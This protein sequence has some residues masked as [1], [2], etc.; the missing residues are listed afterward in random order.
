ML[1]K[2]KFN[3]EAVTNDSDIFNLNEESDY[4]A[5]QETHDQLAD[6]YE[7]QLIA[8]NA[9]YLLKLRSN[10]A[11]T[12]NAIAYIIS[13]TNVAVNLAITAVKEGILAKLSSSGHHE[14][15]TILN[16]LWSIRD[17]NC[18]QGIHTVW[19]QNKF[20]KDNFHFIEPVPVKMGERIVVGSS[21]QNIPVMGYYIPFLD[22]LRTL[23]LMDDVPNCVFNQRRSTGP[24]IYDFVDGS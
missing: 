2:H 8:T 14:L 24:E 15:L 7:K 21:A 13:H 18:F 20:F 16:D 3:N 17:I 10:H 22:S 1:R 6:K 19:L 11:V 4:L 23:L 9:N 12:Q 5:V